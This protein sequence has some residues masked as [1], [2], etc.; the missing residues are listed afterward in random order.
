MLS[1]YE[2][3]RS[4]REVINEMPLY[5]TEN[6]LWD[7]S[8]IPS[9]N[10]T[11]AACWVDNIQP[12]WGGTSCASLHSRCQRRHPDSLAHSVSLR[13]APPG[14]MAARHLRHAC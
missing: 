10:Y 3:R 8:Q 4:Q 5:P 2:R 7:E 13:M 6:V 12:E 9:V 1:T 14:R 11:G